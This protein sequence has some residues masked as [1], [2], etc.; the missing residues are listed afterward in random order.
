[1]TAKA[2]AGNLPLLQFVSDRRWGAELEV[3]SFDGRNRPEQG[4]RPEGIDYVAMLVNR[5]CPSDGC[6]IRDW[7]HTQGNE[8][9]VV[10]PDSS[11]GMEIC[12]PIYKGWT[13]LRK[14]CEVSHALGVDPRVSVDSRCSVHVH[15][16]VADL[17]PDQLGSVIAHWFKIEPVFMDAM[18]PERK[19]NRY[20]QFM[21]MTNL[22]QHDTRITP[23]D[24]T[25]KV[26]N[27]KYYSLNTNQMIRNGRKTVE[28]RIIE[29]AG[30]KDPYLLKNWIRLL[31]HFVEMAAKKPFPGPYVEGDSSSSFC[32]LDPIDALKFLGFWPDPKEYEL[33][34]G[35]RQ[36]RNWFIARLQRYMAKDSEEGPRHFAYKELQ[37]ILQ[38]FKD[39]GEEIVPEKHLSPTD[40]KAVLYDETLVA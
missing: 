4:R 34:P 14:L 40:L 6:E 23:A 11:C 20:C 7:E 35:L 3:N 26:G 2:T 16:E 38:K 5:A 9:W 12:T 22:L 8:G 17:T 30:V 27:V 15:V 10:K 31:I 33:S 28:F 19:R 18:P 25:R 13:G 39:M 29:G 24:L 36:T 21:G 1:M 37:Q 32:W